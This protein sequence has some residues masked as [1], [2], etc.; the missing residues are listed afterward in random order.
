M[1]L[2]RDMVATLG[3]ALRLSSDLMRY[4]LEAQAQALKRTAGRLGLCLSLYL[5]AALVIGT[6]IGF[7]L[8]GV[9]ILVARVAGLGPA[10][11]IV[12]F[13]LLLIALILLLAARSAA[14]RL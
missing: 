9:F 2:L 7:I 4:K 11:L 13:S 14:R 5:A 12:G 10:G 8:Y 1:S 6:G 3:D